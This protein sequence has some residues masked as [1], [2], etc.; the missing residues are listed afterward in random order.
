M[1]LLAHIASRRH[2]IPEEARQQS[3]SV[4][5]WSGA[6][7]RR[8]FH[9]LHPRHHGVAAGLPPDAGRGRGLQR[10]LRDA[11]LR[12]R[13]PQARGR[14]RQGPRRGAGRLTGM[15]TVEGEL[16]TPPAAWS[17]RDDGPGPEHARWHSAIDTS[18]SGAWR[19]SAAVLGFATDEGVERNGGRAARG[20]RPRTRTGRGGQLGRRAG[21]GTRDLVCHPTAAPTRRSGRCT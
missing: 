16:Y 2:M 21:R 10:D 4:P 14:E 20:E 12:H 18:G 19:D 11:V 1:I 5:L 13:P 17:G 3:Y 9:P 15:N 6:V 7:L 8:G